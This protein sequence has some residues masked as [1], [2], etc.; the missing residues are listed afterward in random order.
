MSP[1]PRESLRVVTQIKLKQL[2]VLF[3]VA[4]FYRIKL[5]DYYFSSARNY[6]GLDNELE[7]NLLDLF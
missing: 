4:V 3:L 7:V 1:L 2:L 5:V 6:E